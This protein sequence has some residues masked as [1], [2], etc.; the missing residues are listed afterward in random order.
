MPVSKQICGCP[1]RIQSTEDFLHS[2]CP[3][4]REEYLDFATP[5]QIREIAKFISNFVAGG[6]R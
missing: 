6:A 5:E 4:C 3:A 2:P 1:S